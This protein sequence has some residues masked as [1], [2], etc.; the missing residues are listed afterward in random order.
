MGESEI[1]VII[2]VLNEGGK[3][4]RC[5]KSVFAQSLPPCEVIVIDGKSSDD[6]VDRAKKFPVRMFY[7]DC[8]SIAHGRQLGVEN[9]SGEYLAFTDADCVADKDWLASLFK[10]FC[11]GI[12]AGTHYS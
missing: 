3:I 11:D 1:S 10:E 2:P 7:E 4:E 8:H 12:V 9:A 5:L 6:T